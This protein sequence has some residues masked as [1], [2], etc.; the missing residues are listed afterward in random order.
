MAFPVG[1]GPAIGLGLAAVG[2]GVASGYGLSKA[3]DAIMRKHP[4]GSS[5][6]LPTSLTS[7]GTGVLGAAIGVAGGVA[8]HRGFGKLGLA[9]VTVGA[10]LVLGAVGG[11]IAT[12][13]RH[14]V[15]VETKVQDIF[16]KYD[17]AGFGYR[18]G[19][20]DLEGSFWSPPENYRTDVSHTDRN[21]DGDTNDAG[22]TTRRVY[23]ISR[24][25]FDAD[26]D[27]NRRVELREARDLVA[28]SDRNGDGRLIGDESNSFDRAYGER[29]V[30]WSDWDYGYGF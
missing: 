6:D 26:V 16:S 13:M 9:G 27:D 24:F 29:L 21:D 15:G 7:I 18:D 11:G 23:E 12:S 28:A 3:N 1:V 25:A 14:G 8:M 2:I 4:T 30:S 19:V 10:G 5:G 22:E 20:L 17:G